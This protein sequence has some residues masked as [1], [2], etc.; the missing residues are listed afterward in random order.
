M[1]IENNKYTYTI[2][3][4]EEA[5]AILRGPSL[6]IRSL[7][8]FKYIKEFYLAHNTYNEWVYDDMTKDWR[9]T[10]YGK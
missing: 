3:N 5:P 7:P 6:K 8:W 2:D 10:F 1:E 4:L 9:D